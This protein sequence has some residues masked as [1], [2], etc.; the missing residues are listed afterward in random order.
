MLSVSWTSRDPFN[1]EVVDHASGQVIF[2]LDTPFK[3][4]GTRVTTMTDAQGRVVAEY[5]RRLGYDRVTYQ[6][7]THRVSDW[8][9]KNGLFSSARRLHA[10]DGKTYVWKEKMGGKFKLVDARS[11]AVVAR[12]HA[13]NLGIFSERHN[14]IID[15]GPEIVAFLDVIVLSFVICEGERRARQRDQSAAQMSAMSGASAAAAC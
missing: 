14:I 9:P 10:P 5:E 2:H 15:A 7:Q 8:L 11:D 4:F 6:G 3:I 13:A 12:T 1:A